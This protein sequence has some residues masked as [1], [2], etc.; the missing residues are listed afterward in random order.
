[1]T[2]YKALQSY[3]YPILKDYWEIVS[4]N[5]KYVFSDKNR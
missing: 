4:W 3:L 1:M 2:S 5:Y